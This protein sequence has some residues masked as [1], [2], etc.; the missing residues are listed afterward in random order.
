MTVHFNT[1]DTKV[2]AL[3]T[4]PPDY[5]ESFTTHKANTQDIVQVKDLARWPRV[6]DCPACHNIAATRVVRR[7]GTGTQYV[8]IEPAFITPL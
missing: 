6:V 5:S 1:D 8:L 2:E 3:N 4:M 7:I